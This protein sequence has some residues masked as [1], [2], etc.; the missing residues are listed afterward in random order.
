MNGNCR[1]LPKSITNPLKSCET[2]NLSSVI[3]PTFSN[4]KLH[5]FIPMFE[6]LGSLIRCPDRFDLCV[7]ENLILWKALLR[8]RG[9]LT[10][11]FWPCH[12][13]WLMRLMQKWWWSIFQ[14]STIPLI[15]HYQTSLFK[16]KSMTCLD[17]LPH[18]VPYRLSCP[19]PTSVPVMGTINY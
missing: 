17:I 5:I 2:C 12:C 11:Y 16:K 1:F 3:G 4:D 13:L 9:K 14:T 18:Q 10:N 7:G 8:Y 6:I 15:K 19:V